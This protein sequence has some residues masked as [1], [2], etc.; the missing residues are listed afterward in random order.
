M[1]QMPS[2]IDQEIASQV[3]CLDS[4]PLRSAW[5]KDLGSLGANL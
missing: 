4:Q 5:Q 3:T 2:N 1:I